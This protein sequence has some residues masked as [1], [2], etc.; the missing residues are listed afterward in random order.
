MAGPG[1]FS[2]TLLILWATQAL[3]P[4]VGLA[5]AATAAMLLYVGYN[6]VYTISCYVSGSLADQFPKNRVL[7]IGYA[8][9]VIPAAV[10]L[11]P[12]ESLFKF[13]VVFGFSGLYM[14][15]WETVES[16]TA[17]TLLPGEIR[18]IGFGVLAT[19]NAIGDFVSSA[20]VGFLWV[21]SPTWAMSFVIA[22]SL[23][24]AA[25]IAGTRPRLSERANGNESAN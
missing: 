9:A 10:L 17:A 12:G 8:L 15:V 22:T 11:M 7:A 18:G 25:V 13:G 1:D 21:L 6:I 5:N 20:A 16:T 23:A 19:V 4:Q 24:G 14:G 2:N 3:T